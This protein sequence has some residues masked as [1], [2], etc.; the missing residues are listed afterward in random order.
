MYTILNQW[1]VSGRVKLQA[2]HIK[3]PQPEKPTVN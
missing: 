2:L 1:V 3:D